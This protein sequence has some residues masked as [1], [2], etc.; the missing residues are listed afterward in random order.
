ML[1]IEPREYISQL[2]STVELFQ[3]RIAELE[4]AQEDIGWVQLT[5]DSNYEFSRDHLRRIIA[6]SRLF[7]LQNPLINRAVS[8]QADYVF[9]Q[10]VNIQA[11]NETVNAVIQEFLDDVQNKREL[12]S[13]SSRLLKEQ[14]LLLDGNLFFVLFTDKLETGR[15]QVRTIIVDEIVEIVSNPQDSSDIWYYKRRWL[16]ADANGNQTVQ[17]EAYYPDID[18]KPD[19]NQYGTFRDK[20]VYWDAP[21]LHVKTGS[22]SKA[23]YGV[24]ET[25]S[26]LDWAN[27]HRKML[28]DWATIIAMFARYALKVTTPGN[29]Q[30]VAATKNR[31]QTTIGTAG[32]VVETNPTSAVGSIFVRQ[33]D[34]V[35][36]EPIKT[37]GA[38]T[39][40]TDSRQLRLMVAAAMGLPDPMLSGEVDVG[41]LATAKTL[42]RPTELKF[43]SRQQLWTDVYQKILSWVVRWSIEARQGALNKKV[44]VDIDKFGRLTYKP[45]RDPKTKAPIDLHVE[46]GFP[47]ILERTTQERIDAVIGAVTLNGKSFAIDS[48]EFKKLTIRL[49][50]QALGLNDLDELVEQVFKAISDDDLSNPNNPEQD[51]PNDEPEP[52]PEPIEARA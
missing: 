47:P 37:S 27:A 45:K 9:A 44:R 6:R 51:N 39:S 12:T 36:I 8:L 2:E 35:D 34:G 25:Y 41:N 16:D 13:H 40:A 17:R 32:N 50:F 26:A 38:T 31:L 4:F 42:D 10:G 1:D 46:V 18:Y 22:L 15:V 3:E 49:M 20:Q 24:P 14:T 5:G 29:R 21:I 48:P 28:S 33:K 19:N 11:T 30:S 43:R 7:F 52:E 23:K